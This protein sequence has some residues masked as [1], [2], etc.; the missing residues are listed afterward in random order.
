MVMTN[1]KK[2]KERD[3]QSGWYKADKLIEIL[4]KG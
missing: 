3:R 2:V 1:Y 4:V